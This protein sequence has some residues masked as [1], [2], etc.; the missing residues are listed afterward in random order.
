MDLTFLNFQFAA[1]VELFSK[2]NF[3][4]YVLFWHEFVIYFGQLQVKFVTKLHQQ[5]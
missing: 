4:S 1:F 3:F 5:S 2:G